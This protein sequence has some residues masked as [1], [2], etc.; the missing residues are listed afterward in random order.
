MLKKSL[1]VSLCIL[2]IL[3]MIGCS[4]SENDNVEDSV[5]EETLTIEV[6]PM[7]EEYNILELEII[8][9]SN[10]N[11]FVHTYYEAQNKS[12]SLTI[13]NLVYDYIIV[14]ENGEEI[15]NELSSSSDSMLVELGPRERVELDVSAMVDG[16]ASKDLFNAIT[17]Y[18]FDMDN[19]CYTVDLVNEKVTI[20]DI[21]YYSNVDFN[22][23][24]ILTFLDEESN[25]RQLVNNG[26][27]ELKTLEVTYVI[28]ADGIAKNVETVTAVELGEQPI[29][30]NETASWNYTEDEI[31]VVAYTYETGV[32]D[33]DSFN[34]FEINLITGTAVGSANVVIL[35]SIS[36]KEAVNSLNEFEI[37][38]SSFGKKIEETDFEIVKIV[39]H[40]GLEDLHLDEKTTFLGLPGYTMLIRDYDTLL[41]KGFKFN[42]Y[43]T[44]ETT[45][46][47]MLKT[48]EA[49]FGTDYETDRN[50][51]NEIDELT[52][53]LE[54]YNVYYFVEY[55]L[56][57]VQTKNFA[58]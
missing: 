25:T 54:D 1:C 57:S 5:E 7:F 15:K 34:R 6:D 4:S 44:D 16:N 24:N 58:E 45:R 31:E 21:E 27:L 51:K 46:S 40:S 38:T 3:C 39:E 37:Y 12:D 42:T 32:A 20:A 23:K 19:K 18:S 14:D 47:Y 11:S 29:N 52:W 56:I 26:D 33:E 13:S 53:E 36:D 22:E 10:S 17:G 48:L 2:M 8:R 55:C 50:S 35:D 49:T 41:I 28:Y 43:A 9:R 30:P